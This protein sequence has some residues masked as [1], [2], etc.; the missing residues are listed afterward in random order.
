ML[1]ALPL[2]IHQKHIELSANTNGLDESKFIDICSVVQAVKSLE[3]ITI[4]A[5]GN[6]LTNSSLK[7]LILALLYHTK[8]KK[9]QLRLAK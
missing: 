5:T 4:S 9:V 6:E 8:L 1:N 7:P 2:T 3:S